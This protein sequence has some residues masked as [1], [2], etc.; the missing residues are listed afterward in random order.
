MEFSAERQVT[1]TLLP[2]AVQLAND[3]IGRKAVMTAEII[4]G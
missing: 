4:A 2:N 3:R 1:R